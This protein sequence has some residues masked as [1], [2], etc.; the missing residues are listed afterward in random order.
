M[1]NPLGE[2]RGEHETEEYFLKDYLPLHLI[3]REASMDERRSHIATILRYFKLPDVPRHLDVGCALGFMLEAAKAVGWNSVGVETSE[4]AA[5]YA[6][7][8]TGCSVHA[9]TLQKAALPSQ[10]LDVVT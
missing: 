7:D 1:V 5:R 8:H 10:S 6:A 3:S 2:F 9:S 4:F